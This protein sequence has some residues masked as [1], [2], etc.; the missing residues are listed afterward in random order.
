[1]RQRDNETERQRD[2]ETIINLLCKKKGLKLDLAASR[3]TKNLEQN[4]NPESRSNSSREFASEV[5]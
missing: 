4:S 1:M 3:D 5:C 2:R